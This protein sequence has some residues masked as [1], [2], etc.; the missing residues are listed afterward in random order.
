MNTLSSTI[1]DFLPTARPSPLSRQA[2]RAFSPTRT[3]TDPGRRALF[4]EGQSPLSRQAEWAFS[5]TRTSTDGGT[6]PSFQA[7]RVEGFLADTDQHRPGV[8]ALFPSRQSSELGL[9]YQGLPNL[10]VLII[11]TK[12]FFAKGGLQLQDEEI[13]LSSLLQC[14]PNQLPRPRKLPKPRAK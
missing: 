14:L 5:P 10:R 4:P 7:G 9:F 2:E 12:F 11:F 3:S 1:H 8:R 6:E 13:R